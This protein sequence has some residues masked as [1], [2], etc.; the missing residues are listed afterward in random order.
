[1]AYSPICLLPICLL[2]IAMSGAGPMSRAWRTMAKTSFVRRQ[3]IGK[4]WAHAHNMGKA[5]AAPHGPDP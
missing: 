3:T 2:P 4:A 5:W 1:M